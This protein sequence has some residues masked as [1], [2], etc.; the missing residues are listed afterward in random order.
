MSPEELVATLQAQDLPTAQRLIRVLQ[1]AEGLFE[2][3]QAVRAGVQQPGALEM[4]AL[5]RALDRFLVRVD[6]FAALP[7]RAVRGALDLSQGSAPKAAVLCGC[8]VRTAV[9]YR[10]AMRKGGGG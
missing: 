6:G 10:R 9:D 8:S 7:G 5:E 2:L 1:I 3:A 4:E